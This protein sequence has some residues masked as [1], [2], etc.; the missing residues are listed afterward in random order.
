MNLEKQY[1]FQREVEGSRERAKDDRVKKQ[2]VEQ[3]KLIS[4]RQGSRGELAEDV[5]V[6]SQILGNQ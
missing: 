2:A 1:G 6:L 3:S 5:D 4:Q